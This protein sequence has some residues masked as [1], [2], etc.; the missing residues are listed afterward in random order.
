M[1]QLFISYSYTAKQDGV[2]YQGFDNMVGHKLIFPPSCPEHVEALHGETDKHCKQK[3][4]FDTAAT[5][6]LF[7]KVLDG[8]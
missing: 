7:W 6:I 3:Y 1:S 8:N 2:F 5:T 4:G